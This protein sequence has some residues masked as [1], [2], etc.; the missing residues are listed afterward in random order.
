LQITPPP[1]RN[2]FISL[3]PNVLKIFKT[4]IVMNI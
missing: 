4:T 2:N 3:I 1:I